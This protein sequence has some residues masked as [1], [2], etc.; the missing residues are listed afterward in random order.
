M[1]L[2]EITQ[3]NLRNCEFDDPVAWEDFLSTLPDI[4]PISKTID[5][6]DDDKLIRLYAIDDSPYRHFIRLNTE[7]PEI[8]YGRLWLTYQ[9]RVRID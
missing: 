3:R 5:G 1:S 2:D 9:T 8:P 6:L 7:N 4:I